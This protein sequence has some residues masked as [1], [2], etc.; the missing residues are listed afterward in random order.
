MLKKVTLQ[1]V[2]DWLEI[3]KNLT[4]HFDNFGKD[5][6]YFLIKY[7]SPA[8]DTRTGLVY[9]VKAWGGPKEF[10]IHHGDEGGG[11]I[12][13]ALSKKIKDYLQKSK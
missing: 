2:N 11:T 8:I 6:R 4:W 7:I 5:D 3:H 9:Y 1:E 10:E 13:S 12:L